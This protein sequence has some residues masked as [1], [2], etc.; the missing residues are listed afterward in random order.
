M[1]LTFDDLGRLA[2]DLLGEAPG[3]DHRGQRRDERGDAAVGDDDAVDQAYAGA[4]H[5]G[6]E[7][8]H[9]GAVALGGHGRAQTLARASIAPTDRSMP[10]LM[11]TK[12]IPIAMTPMLDAER[13]DGQLVAPQPVRREEDVGPAPRP[14]RR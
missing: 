7:H 8:H 2:G 13:E 10:P 11:M 5:E 6:D 4:D 14:D 1:P 3:R 9:Q 12:V